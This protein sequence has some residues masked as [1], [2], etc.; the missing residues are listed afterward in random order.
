MQD[1][2]QEIEESWP[3]C[4]SCSA[5]SSNT[6]DIH[7]NMQFAATTAR[8]TA[9]YTCLCSSKTYAAPALRLRFPARWS[10]SDHAGPSSETYTNTAAGE[11]SDDFHDPAHA[12]ALTLR[13]AKSKKRMIKRV[14]GGSNLFLHKKYSSDTLLAGS[15]L[16]R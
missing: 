5:R 14:R 9:A 3:S 1:E 11:E 15:R 13:I 2:A 8:R 16:C 4:L 10:S 7:C 12:Q 6:V